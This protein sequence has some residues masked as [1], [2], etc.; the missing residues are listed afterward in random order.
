MAYRFHDRLARVGTRMSES[1]ELVTLR[2]GAQSTASITAFLILQRAEELIPG[3][4][5]TRVEYQDFTINVADY[6]IGGTAVVPLVGDQIERAN[7]EKFAVSSRGSDQ[8]PFRY[9]TSDRNRYRIQTD[10]VA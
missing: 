7:G 4:S 1:G 5:V 3:V 2:R 8:P 10:R 6:K 9:T